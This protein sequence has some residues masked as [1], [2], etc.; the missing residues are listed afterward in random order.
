MLANNLLKNIS[1][2][3]CAFLSLSIQPQSLA[4]NVGSTGSI[5]LT[6]H[7]NE[8][9]KAFAA[10][11]YGKAKEEYR[12]AIGLSPDNLDYYYGLYDVCVHS[13]EW[14]QVVYALKRIFEIDPS[15][16]QPLLAQ[17]GEA[18][19]HLGQYDEAGACFKTST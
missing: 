1:F 18:L 17:Y 13:G 7:V 19:Y 8:A 15:K 2:I 5:T 12:K 3:L 14:D 9:A 16:R 4:D 10:K 6:K 11:D